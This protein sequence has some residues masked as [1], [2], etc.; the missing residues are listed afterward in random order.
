MIPLFLMYVPYLREGR[1][2]ER[3]RER[4]GKWFTTQLV[5]IAGRE[6]R[7]RRRRRRRREMLNN[8]NRKYLCNN[9]RV[10]VCLSLWARAKR[11]RSERERCVEYDSLLYSSERSSSSSS[12]LT[13]VPVQS[14]TSSYSDSSFL[15]TLVYD[16]ISV[17][18]V[19]VWWKSKK[20]MSKWGKERGPFFFFII[21]L[22]LRAL[23]NGDRCCRRHCPSWTDRLLIGRKKNLSN[24]SHRFC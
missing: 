10:G 23:L 6:E 7:R 20:E 2:E 13:V 21:W 3:R 1:G 18:R 22:L 9:Y 5:F 17:Y 24:S 16:P 11:T 12:S 19:R 8:K 4:M 15:S 14:S